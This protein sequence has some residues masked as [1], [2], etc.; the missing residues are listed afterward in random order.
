[1]ETA[2]V[3]KQVGE[4]EAFERQHGSCS[5]E[6]PR[7]KCHKEVWAQKIKE[8]H[9]DSDAAKADDNRGTDGSAIIIPEESG[10]APFRVSAAYVNKHKPQAGGY[11]VVYSGGYQSWSPAAEFEDGYT[12]IR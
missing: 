8:I 6:M 2:D 7:Y 1:M 4:R 11:F 12:R 3:F 9:F 5:A 10:Y